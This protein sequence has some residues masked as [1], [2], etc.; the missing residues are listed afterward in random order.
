MILREGFTQILLERFVGNGMA[1]DSA[2]VEIPTERIPAH[3]R[4]LGSRLLF[5]MNDDQLS[6]EE[7]SDE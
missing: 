6:V 5:V 4:S 1:G 2:F 3:L 7:L